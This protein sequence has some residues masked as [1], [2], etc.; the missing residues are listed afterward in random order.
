VSVA[1]VDHLDVW[2]S[3]GL[4]IVCVSNSNRHADE[5]LQNVIR[6][7]EE[8]LSDGYVSEVETDLLRF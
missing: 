4:G 3:A 5:M 1:E 6:F 7:V 8:H 2:Q